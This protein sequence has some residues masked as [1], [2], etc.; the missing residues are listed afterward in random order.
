MIVSEVGMLLPKEDDIEKCRSKLIAKSRVYSKTW[1]LRLAR[2]CW[3]PVFQLY[4]ELTISLAV[5]NRGLTV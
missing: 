4:P 1:L 5:K 2:A 3:P